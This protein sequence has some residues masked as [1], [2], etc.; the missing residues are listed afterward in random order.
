[1]VHG[2]GLGSETPSFTHVPS[3][4]ARTTWGF[5]AESAAG[6]SG[7]LQFAA[8]VSG[9][10]DQFADPARP[11]RFFDAISAPSASERS[12]IQQNGG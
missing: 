1:M 9:R 11:D 2:C 12:F 8:S 4:V 10:V 3:P 7:I 5:S 6:I